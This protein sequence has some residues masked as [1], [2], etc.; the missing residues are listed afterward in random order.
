MR[1]PIVVVAYNRP[2]SLSRLLG[3]LAKATYPYSDIDLIISIDKAENNQDVLELAN[4]FQWGHGNKKVVYQE[5]NLGLRKHIL[6]CGGLSVEYGAVIVLE[7]DLYVSP[8]F[9]VFTEQALNFSLGESKIGGISLYNHQLNVHTR[10]NFSALEDGYDNWY[11]QFASSWGQAWTKEQW[12]G[13]MEWYE[14]DPNI[15]ANTNVPAY[16]RSWSPKSWLKYNIAYLVE[17]D[18]YFLYPKISLTTNFSDAGTH[19][20]NDST[21]YQVPLDQGKHRQYHFSTVEN[22]FSIYDAFYENTKLHIPLGLDRE[23]LCIDLHGYKPLSGKRYVL[24]PKMMDFV[25]DKSFGK[26]LKPHEDNIFCDTQGNEIFLY[27]TSIVQKNTAV[28]DFDRTVAYNFKQIPYRLTRKLFIRQ[29]FQKMKGLMGK[30]T[31]KR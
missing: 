16:V 2:R 9:Y 27:D 28:Q 17:N 7:D 29:S 26:S 31:K 6:K 21:I 4:G 19:V 25:K 10:D 20:G 3:S 30:I 11:F 8:N 23:E 18:L 24:T 5:Q 15:D 12:S 1:I 22:S 13:F 14:K